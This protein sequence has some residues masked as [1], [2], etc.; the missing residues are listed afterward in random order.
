M[1]CE[2]CKC[3]HLMQDGTPATQCDDS[4]CPCHTPTPKEEWGKEFVTKFYNCRVQDVI[5]EIKEFIRSLLA[6]QNQKLIEEVKGMKKKC[7]DDW[8]EDIYGGVYNKAIDDIL[9]LMRGEI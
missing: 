6:S 4:D 2:K 8:I 1:C 5:N 3:K 7:S 9:K